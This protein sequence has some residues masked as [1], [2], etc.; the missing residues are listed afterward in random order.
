LKT[1]KCSKILV[2][3]PAIANAA[4]SIAHIADN[5]DR[6]IEVAAIYRADYFRLLHLKAMEITMPDSLSGKMRHVLYAKGLIHGNDTLHIFV[7]HWT[8]R[9]RGY[10]ESEPYR[11]LA[12]QKLIDI[13]DSICSVNSN[14]NIIL[15]GD[16]NDNPEKYKHATSY[17]YI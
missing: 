16:F 12:A 3:E 11:I 4:Y 10:L 2:R 5:D 13:T 14:A 1:R 9:Y 15:M 6:G 8:S 17:K 7:N